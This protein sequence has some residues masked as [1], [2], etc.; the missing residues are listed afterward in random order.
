MSF[1]FISTKSSSLHIYSVYC[2]F[3]ILLY[4]GISFASNICTCA[5]IAQ[6]S[7]P[8][9]KTNVT[10]QFSTVCFVSKE[11]LLKTLW[12]YRTRIGEINTLTFPYAILLGF[13]LW[14]NLNIILICLISIFISYSDV[15]YGYK[16]EFWFS[17]Y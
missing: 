9:R 11:M 2:F 16:S 10:Y 14:G 17:G 3:S 6:H 7:L 13:K 4:N 1:C 12:K 5:K 8:N 15:K